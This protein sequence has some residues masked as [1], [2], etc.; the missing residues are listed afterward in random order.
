MDREIFLACDLGAS[1]EVLLRGTTQSVL[2]TIG[3]NDKRE[4][5]LVIAP[6]K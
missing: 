3:D 5:V 1:S 2:K 4:F 6:R